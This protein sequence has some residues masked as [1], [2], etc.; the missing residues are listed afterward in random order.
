MATNH[1]FVG[2][3]LADVYILG[4]GDLGLLLAIQFLTVLTSLSVGAAFAAVWVRFGNRGTTI[5][6]IGLGL[7]LAVALVIL[8]PFFPQIFEAF[9]A[10][11]AG[12]AG[13]RGHRALRARRCT[14][15]SAAPPSGSRRTI[16][17]ATAVAGPFWFLP[18]CSGRSPR[19][20]QPNGC[21]NLDSLADAEVDRIF[22]ALADSTRRDIVR[23]VLQREQSVTESAERWR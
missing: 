8:V 6:G 21:T 11:V 23:R 9:Q 3:H 2:F 7:V 20:V 4:A 18:L 10:V 15:A 14:P 16:G 13:P 12:G 1:W 17:P 19:N 5:M 22:Q